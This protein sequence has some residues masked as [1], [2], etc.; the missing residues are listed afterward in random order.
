MGKG[1]RRAKERLNLQGSLAP[2]LRTMG[3]ELLFLHGLESLG[4]GFQLQGLPLQRQRP[5]AVLGVEAQPQET[6]MPPASHTLLPDVC[7]LRSVVLLG[8]LS[9]LWRLLGNSCP[10]LG[11]L[12]PSSLP[13]RGNGGHPSLPM[14]CAEHPS[15]VGS[16]PRWQQHGFGTG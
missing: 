5:L 16:R 7:L 9:P 15:Q 6:L 4:A 8:C 12:L 14:L 13:I 2:Q 1:T 3:R 11:T 10:K